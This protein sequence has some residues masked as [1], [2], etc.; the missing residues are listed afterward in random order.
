MRLSELV[1]LLDDLFLPGQFSDGCHNG[2]VIPGK[3]RVSRMLVAVSLNRT[4]IERAVEMKAEALLV[5]HGIF[6]SGNWFVPP[7]ISAWVNRLMRNGISLFCY[8]LPM[9]AHAEFSH[10]RYLIDRL[11]VEDVD[12]FSPYGLVGNLP[13]PLGLEQILQRLPAQAWAADAAPRSFDISAPL[14]WNAGR[15]ICSSGPDPVRRV[16]VVSGRGGGEINAAAAAGAQLLVSGEISEHLPEQ[17]SVLGI[18]L[19]ALGHY[20]SETGGL[21]RLG[22][23]L[24]KVTRLDISFFFED[25]PL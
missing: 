24:K 10:N 18:N 6:L 22:E 15:W 21:M 13:T 5:H 17:A 25:N 23:W 9:D 14:Q 4:L 12:A 1:S 11:G 20:L 19:I 3:E 8:H 16:A 7:G 2:L